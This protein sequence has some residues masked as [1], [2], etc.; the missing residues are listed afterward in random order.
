MNDKIISKIN[1]LLALTSSSNEHE[2]A[3]A[4]EMAFKLMEEN[5]ITTQDLNIA[6][7]EEDLGPIKN[8]NLK[9]KSQLCTWEKNLAYIIAD[10]FDCCAYTSSKW[11]PYKDWKIYSVGFVGHE[12][13]RITAITMYEWL[14]KAIQKEANKKFSTYAYQQSYCLGIVIGL[15]EKY[16]KKRDNNSNEAGLVIYDEV[17]SWMKNN[18]TL[19]EGK[20]RAVSITSSAYASGRADS[21]N[22]SL[23]RQF[24]LKAIG[25]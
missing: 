8:E 6:N 17:K 24:G 5:G 21:G 3:K 23:N 20:S 22:Y 2:S 7:L 11:H 4:A 10:Y 12:S 25:C 18:M 1:K 9:Y 14:R 15:S 13:N 19:G 16:T